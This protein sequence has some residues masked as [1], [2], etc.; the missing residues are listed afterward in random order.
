MSRV[1]VVFEGFFDHPTRGHIRIDNIHMSN[2]VQLEQC[3][4][5]SRLPVCHLSTST[6]CSSEMIGPAPLLPTR[7]REFAHMGSRGRTRHMYTIRWRRQK[8]G[9]THPAGADSNLTFI[10]LPPILRQPAHNASIIILPQCRSAVLSLH[11]PGR[12]RVFTSSMTLLH[13][14]KRTPQKMYLHHWDLLERRLTMERHVNTQARV[15]SKTVHYIQAFFCFCF[16]FVLAFS[17]FEHLN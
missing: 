3:T 6:A 9:H 16:F 15:N 4:R 2:S 7:A 8:V 5:K 1:Q 13:W 14:P 11:W 10:S 12:P 17:R